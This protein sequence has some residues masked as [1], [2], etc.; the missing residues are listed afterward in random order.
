MGIWSIHQDENIYPNPEKFNPDRYLNHPKLAN[1]YAT[2]PDYE[3]RGM[4]SFPLLK[5]CLIEA[6]NP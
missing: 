2:S 1:E 3:N 4:L 5:G 6:R